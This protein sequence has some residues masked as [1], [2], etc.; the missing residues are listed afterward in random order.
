MKRELV[1]STVGLLAGLSLAFT[2]LPGCAGTNAAVNAAGVALEMNRVQLDPMFELAIDVRLAEP[3]ITVGDF[4]ADKGVN[5]LTPA[6]AAII[7]E[8]M[9][10]HANTI[11]ELQNFGKED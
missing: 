2:F 10:E 11:I 9:V 8:T 3:T 5:P 6:E 1:A 4:L 7:R